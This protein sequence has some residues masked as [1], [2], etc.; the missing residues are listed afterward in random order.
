[1]NKINLED[2]SVGEY[3]DNLVDRLGLTPN[4]RTGLI[5]ICSVILYSLTS[6]FLDNIL[7]IDNQII[8]EISDGLAVPIGIL[9]GPPGAIGVGTGV[10]V[11]D[12]LNGSLFW[13]SILIA[14]AQVVLA[15]LSYI[16]WR[17]FPWL[18][19]SFA[20]TNYDIRTICRFSLV[21]LVS[22]LIAASFLA[23]TYEITGHF[24]FYVSF[25]LNFLDFLIASAFVSTIIFYPLYR[26]NHL[27]LMT[28]PVDASVTGNKMTKA[29]WTVIAV[30]AT[31][32]FLGVIGSVGFDIRTR[33][34]IIQFKQRGLSLVY[35]LIH[36]NIFG[37]GGRRAQVV[38]G[39]LMLLILILALK[40]LPAQ[41]GRR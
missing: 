30:S 19:P 13:E 9:F 20:A 7:V 2:H 36:P 37:H 38:F 28:H 3:I 32:P 25:S 21:T 24:P 11:A 29:D 5:I 23:W 26:A 22:S 31:W 4:W 12:F 1:M 8:I 33:I 15:S 41:T 34:S 39:T 10:L 17:R 27:P 18:L 40:Q 16:G 14:S 35:E 6:I